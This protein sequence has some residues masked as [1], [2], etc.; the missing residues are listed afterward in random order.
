MKMKWIDTLCAWLLV[1]L[2]SAHFLA[3]Y[4]PKLS[5]LRCPW[6]GGTAIAIISIGLMN[7]VRS[8]RKSDRFLRWNTAAATA[9]TTA[10][11]MKVLY[12]FPGNVLHQPAA[13][14][15]AVLAAIELVF[16]VAG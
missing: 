16:A 3:A 7:A 13:L 2:G 5:L 12:Q 1:I 10:L 8:Q 15:T 6:M 9:L 14:A 11:C 4:I